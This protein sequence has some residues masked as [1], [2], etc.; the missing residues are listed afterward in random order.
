MKFIDNKGITDPYINLALEEYVLQHFGEKDTY[1]LFYINEPSVIMGKNQNSAEEINTENIDKN[2]IKVKRSL[3]GGGA[4]DDDKGNMNVRLSS[5][6]RT[7]EL[8]ARND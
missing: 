6:E 2:N 7:G 4:I 8:G 3:Y 1:L 5:E